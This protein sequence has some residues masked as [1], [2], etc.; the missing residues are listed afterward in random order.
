MKIRPHSV[1]VLIWQWASMLDVDRYTSTKSWRTLWVIS[2]SLSHYL[3]T[4]VKYQ[5]GVIFPFD[6]GLCWYC[7]GLSMPMILLLTI[8]QNLDEDSQLF[9]F[10]LN[11]GFLFPQTF[12]FMFL[13]EEQLYVPWYIVHTNIH[14]IF[15]SASFCFIYT[16]G[17][18]VPIWRVLLLIHYYHPMRTESLGFGYCSHYQSITHTHFVYIIM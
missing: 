17:S 7:N 13:G 18:T 16:W 11:L 10:S 9:E 4:N 8:R 14:N 6:T 5:P 2:R 1:D 12:F 3:W 15:M